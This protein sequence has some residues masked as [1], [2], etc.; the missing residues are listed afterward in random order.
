M[1][2]R[3]GILGLP[4]V[5]LGQICSQFC[6]HC[7]GEDCA[8]GSELPDSFRGPEYFGTLVALTQVNVRIGGLAQMARLHVFC[9]RRDSLPL[10]ARTLVERPALAA[11]IRVV[12][13]G[14]R[15]RDSH[16]GCIL[17]EL[18]TPQ[19]VER[20]KALLA[21]ELGADFDILCARGEQRLLAPFKQLPL[22]EDSFFSAPR[23]ADIFLGVRG[24][25]LPMWIPG[26]S[27]LLTVSPCH[28][29]RDRIANAR[30][31]AFLLFKL[32]KKIQCI[33][34][35]SEWPL[36]VFPEPKPGPKIKV[37]QAASVVDLGPLPAVEELRL[38]SSND[39]PHFR[40][41]KCLV[42][43]RKCAG[44]LSHLT[45]LC[46]LDIRGGHNVLSHEQ[47]LSCRP[48]LVN[49]T[50]L[51]LTATSKSTLDDILLCCSPRSLKH[52]RFTI[53][54]V[55][56]G[57]LRHG[58]DIQ[59]SEIINLL[60]EHRHCKTLETLHIDTSESVMFAADPDDIR[61][62][63][64]TVDTLSHFASL[65]HLT[66]SADSIYYPSLYPR[67]LLRDPNTGKM[68]NRLIRFL[69]SRLES[70]EITGIYAIYSGD[71]N[72]LADECF[73]R[74]R[75]QNLKKVT[76]KGH[77]GNMLRPLGGIPYPVPEY[78]DP[79]HGFDDWYEMA[80]E[81]QNPGSEIDKDIAG[82]FEAAGVEY[83]FDMPEFYFD[84]FAGDWDKDPR[85]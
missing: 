26:D 55:A 82:C 19:A 14:D 8:G 21:L 68:G 44:L 51:N 76:L 54:P 11:H 52:F 45:G 65:R 35:L 70:L 42:D 9:G 77:R 83:G 29:G 72:R 38:D 62:E 28:L 36:A 15:D 50:V 23:A 63:F 47:V 7:C 40:S 71:V 10:L 34:I 46:I 25:R 30:F 24:D 2:R 17:R 18:A 80:Y 53:P 73:R 59:G 79:E 84:A 60:T 12:R 16:H 3:S 13:L 74:G 1:S 31:N 61:L 22:T 56:D 32:A 41:H 20:L 75:L 5:V 43:I 27:N 57:T 67:V 6:P 69:P 4:D 66:I 33:A 49:I 78:D 39:N 64:K 85:A 58:N 81:D 48:A 37:K